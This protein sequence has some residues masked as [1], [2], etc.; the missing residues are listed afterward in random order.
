LRKQNANTAVM[1][2]TTTIGIW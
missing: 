2:Q 1:F